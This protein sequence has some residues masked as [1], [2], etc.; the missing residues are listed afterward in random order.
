MM[1]LLDLQAD[2]IAARRAAAGR[3]VA[4]LA[5][6]RQYVDLAEKVGQIAARRLV[7]GG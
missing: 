6:I 1:A 5:L 4:D 7:R 3:P 2:L